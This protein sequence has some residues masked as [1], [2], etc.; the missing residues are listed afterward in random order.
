MSPW[1]GDDRL[2]IAVSAQALED[3]SSQGAPD[4][5]HKANLAKIPVHQGRA[6]AEVILITAFEPT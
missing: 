1:S 4:L 5:V 3:P 2:D 6:E